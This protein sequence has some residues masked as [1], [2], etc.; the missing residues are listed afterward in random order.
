MLDPNAPTLAIFSHPNHE[1]AVYGLMR[2]LKPGVCFLTDGGGGLRRAQTRLGLDAAG[3]PIAS[4]LDHTEASFYKAVLSRDK[5]FYSDVADQVGEII[6]EK[7]PAQILVDGVEYY[8]PIHDMALPVVQAALRRQGKNIPVFAVPLVYQGG[9]DGFVFQRSLPGERSL[10]ETF[11]IAVREGMIKRAA[12]MDI[13]TVLMGQMTFPAA[14][15]DQ[16]C[17]EEHLVPAGSPLCAVDP[18]CQIRYNHRGLEAKKAGLVDGAILYEDHY[19]P[20]VR[21]LLLS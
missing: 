3:I 10:E 1:V 5:K 2:A 14:V 13:Y 17:R 16:A 21:D 12:L 6:R 7:K 4:F 15:I 19:L 8:N 9:S 18:N 11:P 20:L